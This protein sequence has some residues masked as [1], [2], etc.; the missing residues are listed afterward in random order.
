MPLTQSLQGIRILDLT[1]LLPGP[2][3]T[4]ILADLGADVCKVEQP[5]V[6]DYLR[7]VPPLVEGVGARFRA[8]NRG[9][10]SV[11][12][13]LGTEAGR[14]VVRQLAARSDVVVEGFRPGV[15]ARLGLDFEALQGVRP[16]VILCSISGYG[17][18][19]PYRLR[20]GHDLNYLALAGL[21]AE[22]PAAG[23]RHP[24][25]LPI[26]IADLVGGG[27]FAVVSI[28]AA[29]L[30]RARDPQPQPRHLDI[31]MTEGVLALMASEIAELLAAG[32]DRPDPGQG[33]LSGGHATYRLYRT[34]DDRW[35][36]VG[37]LEPKFAAALGEV[38]GFEARADEMLAGPA[39][40]QELGSLIAERVRARPLSHWEQ[41]FASVDACVEPALRPE[42][43][44]SHPQHR[45]RAVFRRD[46]HNPQGRLSTDGPVETPCTR[47][48]LERTAPRLG[49]HTR[50][51]LTELG[52]TPHEIDALLAD[53]IVE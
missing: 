2:Y 43:L 20:A 23:D 8:V 38:L 24:A 13:D 34:A 47:A 41:A 48:P 49:E 17:Q 16:D 44:A 7:L 29:L 28:L 50:E 18:D 21:L 46:P 35:L 9:K 10:R 22:M 4:Q 12:V 3:G 6:G 32:D 25:P 42:E 5:G 40:Q 31:S 37:A 15:L 11:A 19:G 45:A 51:V 33:L 1:R 53:R 27:L 36:S 39:R 14:E 30:R 26:Q 52:R